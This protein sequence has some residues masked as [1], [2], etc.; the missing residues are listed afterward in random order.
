MRREVDVAIAASGIDHAH[1]LNGAFTDNFLH[2]RFGGVFDMAQGT[3]SYWGDGQDTFDATS[4]EDTARYTARAA[5]DRDLPNG[6]LAIVGEQ[7]TFSAIIDAVETVFGQSFERRSKGSIADLEA[8][9]AAQQAADPGS[10]E[11]L[12]DTYLL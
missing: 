6:K 11:A 8:T 5:L 12:G 10:M 4:V 9:I 2:S 1:A 7:I 3:A